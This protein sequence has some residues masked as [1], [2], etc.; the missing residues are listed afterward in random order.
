MY[1][2]AKYH[3]VSFEAAALKLIFRRRTGGFLSGSNRVKIFRAISL[4]IFCRV[5]KISTRGLCVTRSGLVGRYLAVLDFSLSA[6]VQRI[7]TIGHT[8]ANNTKKFEGKPS[9]I[10]NLNSLSRGLCF[11]GGLHF[12][13]LRFLGGLHFLGGLR[14]LGV[15]V[16]GS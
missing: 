6:S 8:K 16:F 14:F 15:F 12:L 4:G 5:T 11:L 10:Y 13:G 3:F 1:H 9:A 7:R 2:F